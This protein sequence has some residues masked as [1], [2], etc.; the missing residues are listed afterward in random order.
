MI[1]PVAKLVNPTIVQI[2][3]LLLPFGVHRQMQ[4]LL[5]YISIYL[6]KRQKYF[7]ALSFFGS[8]IMYD[9]DNCN[10]ILIVSLLQAVV[11]QLFFRSHGVLPRRRLPSLQ[12]ASPRQT[13]PQS[14]KGLHPLPMA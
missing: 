9:K 11:T 5:W 7:F 10:S 3:F 4:T 14:Q 13:A 8:P 2:H 6:K 12:G 1:I